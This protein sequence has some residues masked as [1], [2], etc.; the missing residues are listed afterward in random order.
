[1]RPTISSQGQLQEFVTSAQHEVI[2]CM[3]ESTADLKLM[4]DQLRQLGICHDVYC[5][6]PPYKHEYD[7]ITDFVQKVEKE[8]KGETN[9]CDDIQCWKCNLSTG[10]L[11]T[12]RILFENMKADQIVYLPGSENNEESLAVDL[13]EFT[14]GSLSIIERE[15]LTRLDSDICFKE[16]ILSLLKDISS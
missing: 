13:Q 16:F 7:I 14:L 9:I 10:T 15:W 5:P 8:K 1:M 2:C 12:L 3:C 11:V 6:F 4:E